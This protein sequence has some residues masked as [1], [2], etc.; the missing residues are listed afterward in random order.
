RAHQT[1]QIY[2]TEVAESFMTYLKVALIC[3]GAIASPWMVYQLWQFVA[4][5]LYPRERKYI[6]KYLPLSIVLLM[7]GMLF[8]YFIVLPLMMTFFL[9][10]NFGPG[11]LVGPA[12]IDK[13]ASTQPALTIPLFQGDP[14]SPADR[15]IWFDATQHRLKLFLDGETR[16]IQFGTAGVATPLITLA[17]YID[18]VVAMLLSFGVAFQMPLVVLALVRIGIVDVPQLKKMRKLV[19]FSMSI[20]AAFIVP[21][22]VTGMVALLIPLIILFEMGLWLAREKPEKAEA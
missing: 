9:E 12:Q 5:G 19:Y 7:T 4:A 6:T 10:F 17:T 22:V 2:Y 14:A 11:D 21:D 8:L 1:P 3:A 16:V 20:V 15:Q 13:V 18:M